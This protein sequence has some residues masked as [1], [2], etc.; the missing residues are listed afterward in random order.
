MRN[1]RTL[2][3]IPA[4]GGSRRIP[5]KNIKDFLGQPIIKYSIDTVIKSN[6]FDEIMVSTDDKEIARIAIECGAKVPFF[7]SAQNSNDHATTADVIEEVLQ[8]YQ[9][10]GIN[11]DYV[12]C[13]YATAPFIK[14]DKIIRAKRLLEKSDADSILPVSRYSFPIQRS[15]NINSEGFLVL[16][17]PQNINTRSQDLVPSYHDA[18]QFYLLKVSSFLKQKKLFA[19]KTIPIITSEMEVQDMDCEEDWKIAEAKYIILNKIHG[20]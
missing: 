14:A 4:R 8:E 9:K 10:R 12:C 15:F 19:E 5:R 2:A 13:L 17:W 7:R 6:C 18:G 3:V 16:N 1:K 20:E 11:Y